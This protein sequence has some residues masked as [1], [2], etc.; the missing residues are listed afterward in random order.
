[1]KKIIFILV[2]TLA[3]L[4]AYLYGSSK[5]SE[6]QPLENLPAE[7][8]VALD[9]STGAAPK[10]GHANALAA[11]LQESIKLPQLPAYQCEESR[12]DYAINGAKYE[13]E[14]R[15][16]VRN[17]YPSDKQLKMLRGMSLAQLS[18]LADKGHSAARV[19]AAEK[20]V[21]NGEAGK[22]LGQMHEAMLS[23]SVYATHAFANTL[24]T[25]DGLKNPMEAA[26]FYR[27]AYLQGDWKAASELHRRFPDMDPMQRDM[28]D[29]R[30][31]RLLENMNRMRAKRGILIPITNR[32]MSYDS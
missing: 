13:K 8:S 29:K 27:L 32:P 11:S 1:M 17:G 14:A 15:W 30:A 10:V 21:A 23:G 28:V 4:A 2:M 22:G 25:V 24:L 19:V 6:P 5:T 16:L 31:M 7:K 9:A 18:E 12:C 20:M 26:A 3:L